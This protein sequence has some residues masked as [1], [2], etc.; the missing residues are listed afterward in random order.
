MVGSAL[1]VTKRL[2]RSCVAK[3]NVADLPITYMVRSGVS[4]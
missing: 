2:K 1:L 3:V 4:N